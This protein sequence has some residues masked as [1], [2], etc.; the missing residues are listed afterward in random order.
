[1]STLRSRS[2]VRS[3]LWNCWECAVIRVRSP[4][5]STTVGLML[6][7]EM[8]WINTRLKKAFQTWP[9]CGSLSTTTRNRQ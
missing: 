2:C 8:S 3:L 9:G 7:A 5:S 6:T 1:R 4:P